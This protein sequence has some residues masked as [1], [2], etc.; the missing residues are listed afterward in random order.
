MKHDEFRELAALEAYGEIDADER[1][2]LDVH[3]AEC[4]ECR[5]LAAGL[6]RGLGRLASAGGTEDL[7]AGWAERIRES[8]RTAPRRRASAVR[9]AFAAGV[10]AGIAAGVAVAHLA[11]AA[12]VPAPGRAP[13]S[14]HTAEFG[15]ETPPPRAASFGELAHLGRSRR[16]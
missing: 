5:D 3:R 8:A 9:L 6:R 10:A 12:S 4:A 13:E 7:P 14:G 2:R 16:G 15:R 11:L 1:A